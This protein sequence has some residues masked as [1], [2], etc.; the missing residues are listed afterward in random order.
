MAIDAPAI[1]KAWSAALAVWDAQV[2]LSPPE[3]WE[4]EGASKGTPKGRRKGKG[5][6]KGG[7]DGDEPLAYI[8]LTTRHVVVNFDLLSR[9]GAEKSLPAVLA[10]EIGHHVAFPHTLGLSAA[11]EVLQERLIPGHGESLTNLFFDLQVN[12]VVGRTR[13]EELAA[14][15]RGFLAQS[16]GSTSPLF[17]TY[18]A[19]YEELW[20]LTPGALLGA[21]WGKEMEKRY[22]GFRAE[23]RVFAQTFYALPDTHLQF[24]YFCAHVIRYLPEPGTPMGLLALSGDVPVPGPDDYA[25]A[26]GGSPQADDALE[27]AKRRGWLPEGTSAERD[28]IDVIDSL[29]RRFGGEGG[30]A[31]F[32]K[33]LVADHYRRL[34]DQ[35]LVKLPQGRDLPPPDPSLPTTLEEWEPGDPVRAIDWTASILASG[36]MAVAYPLKRE[37]EAETP[38]EKEG[39]VP[40]LAIYV[41]TSGSMPQPDRALNAMTLSAQILCS[42]AIRKGA[43]VKGVV[44][45]AGKPL[46]SDWM[47]DEATARDFLLQYAGGGNDRCPLPQLE[48]ISAETPDAL[49]VVISDWD[50]LGM[51][52][53]EY[54]KGAKPL[55]DAASRSRLVVTLL[56]LPGWAE[57]SDRSWYGRGS[58]RKAIE[59]ALS[60][61]RFRLV[62]VPDVVHLAE[63]AAKLARALLGD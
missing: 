46:V 57:G 59:P 23:A 58:P 13:A 1:A 43:R 8:D 45:S 19:I 25:R 27:E 63:T 55:T 48:Q 22:P 5:K 38:I 61:P 60:H 62:A 36:P 24:A 35:Y 2:S 10:H 11:L 50:L 26:L 37:M 20:G 53:P 4:G 14:V 42:S 52:I 16:G 17:S 33:A 54:K 39:A 7:G 41:D 56:H 44:Y 21:E 40:P 18:L 47:R 51:S 34:V 9:L 29:S 32:K 3:A 49:H 15:Y 12:E 28:P 6:G 31:A 30:P